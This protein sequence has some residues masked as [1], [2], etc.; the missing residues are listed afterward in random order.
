MHKQTRIRRTKGCDQI[1]TH[2]HMHTHMHTCIYR[3]ARAFQ[4]LMH[5]HTGYGLRRIKECDYKGSGSI[6]PRTLSVT[7]G[8]VEERRDNCGRGAGSCLCT[9]TQVST[10]APP[11]TSAISCSSTRHCSRSPAARH[12]FHLPLDKEIHDVVTAVL[13]KGRGIFTEVTHNR[14]YLSNPTNNPTIPT[15]PTI[16]INPKNPTNPRC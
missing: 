3:H 11:C 10:P 16:P 5:A 1:F 2:A 7:V 8:C 9:D 13:K 6:T 15:I 12:L 4:F 14:T